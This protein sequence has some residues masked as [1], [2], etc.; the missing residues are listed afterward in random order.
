MPRNAEW[1][2]KV[3][4]QPFGGFCQRPHQLSVGASIRTECFRGGIDRA[5]QHRGRSVVQRVRER[6]RRVNPLQ[7]V[8]CQREGFEERRRDRHRV[9][10]GA[11]VVRESRQ[12]ERRGPRPA[13]DGIGA[14]DHKNR[15]TLLGKGDGRGKS[16]WPGPDDHRGGIRHVQPWRAE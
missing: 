14:L 15:M 5:F 1:A 12:R 11:D 6:R 13:A 9:N 8:F 7:S 16:V 2:E 10:R 4:K 3:G